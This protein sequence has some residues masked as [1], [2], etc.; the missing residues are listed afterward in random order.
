MDN[1]NSQDFMSSKKLRCKN[2][3]NL[4]KSFDFW[5]KESLGN[6]EKYVTKITQT[7]RNDF[8]SQSLVKLNSPLLKEEKDFLKEKL[9]TYSANNTGP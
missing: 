3:N 6:F 8:S 5:I 7:F 9:I 2:V 1:S 4:Y